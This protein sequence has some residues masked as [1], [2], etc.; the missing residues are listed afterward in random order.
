MKQ[1]LEASNGHEPK[2]L[3]DGT[4][5]EQS[6]HHQHHHS[7]LSKQTTHSLAEM[8][9]DD[10]VKDDHNIS[11]GNPTIH[12]QLSL[13]TQMQQPVPYSHTAKNWRQLIT[14]AHDSFK[15]LEKSRRPGMI[16]YSAATS[17]NDA[18]NEHAEHAGKQ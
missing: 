6:I 17:S 9:P 11:V 14:P 18:G 8:L 3:T 15:K 10:E 2:S 1:K 13:M 4:S 12:T 7:K 16:D 5:C